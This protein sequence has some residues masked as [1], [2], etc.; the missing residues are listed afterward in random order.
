MFKLCRSQVYLTS[1]RSPFI[2]TT[3]RQEQRYVLLL[4]VLLLLANAPAGYAQD[5]DSTGLWTI[6]TDTFDGYLKHSTATRLGELDRFVKIDNRL[7]LTY[8]DWLSDNFG[9]TLTGLAVYDVEK[10]LEVEDEEEYRAYAD[11]RE[12]FVDLTLGDFDMRFGR[13]QVT[14]GKTDGF[15][16]TDLV[17]PLDLREFGLADFLDSKIPLWMGKIDSWLF[18][19]YALLK[20]LMPVPSMRLRQPN[21][22]QASLR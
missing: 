3:M 9:V 1:S 17:N 7:K 2:D 21:F 16:I 19:T 15:R 11:L 22:R 18:P 13:Q 4:L 10:E 6:F 14:W 12:A 20:R 5:D 8:S